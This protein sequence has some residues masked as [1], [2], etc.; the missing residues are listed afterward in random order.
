MSHCAVTAI[1]TH[2]KHIL[3]AAK[4][5]NHKGLFKYHTTMP[6]KEGGRG[7][8]A[9]HPMQNMDYNVTMTSFD[10]IKFG[11]SLIMII[12]QPLFCIL[13]QMLDREW[14]GLYL[15]N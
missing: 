13:P 1:Q 6:Q 12:E 8:K 15:T 4:I 9:L 10:R 14:L 7:N 2:V 11:K 3:G 5:K